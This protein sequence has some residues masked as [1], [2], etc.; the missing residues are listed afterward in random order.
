M[1]PRAEFLVR[2]P[3]MLEESGPIFPGSRWALT[4]GASLLLLFALTVSLRWFGGED[5]AR[6]ESIVQQPVSPE[7]SAAAATQRSEVTA[8]DPGD[9]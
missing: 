5:A 2:N 6:R 8:P 4:L 1:P 3:K 7:V 9:N